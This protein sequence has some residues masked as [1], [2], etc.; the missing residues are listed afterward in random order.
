MVTYNF[1]EV[2]QMN[3]WTGEREV[4]GKGMEGMREESRYLSEPDGR[5]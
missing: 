1:Q 3:Q 5:L 2:V 4:C